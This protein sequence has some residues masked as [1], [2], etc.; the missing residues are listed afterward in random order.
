MPGTMTR[1]NRVRTSAG[2]LRLVSRSGRGSGALRSRHVALIGADASP[3][4]TGFP[5]FTS[6]LH[7][8][9]SDRAGRVSR[10]LLSPMT[11]PPDLVIAAV[12]GP[13]AVAAG[14]EFAGRHDVPLLVVVQG[15]TVPL[16]EDAGTTGARLAARLENRSLGRADRW[17][18][19]GSAARERLLRLGV[20][21]SRI[22]RLPYW[23]EP[24]R[25]GPQVE[26]ERLAVRRRLGRPAGFL[27]VCPVGARTSGAGTVIAAAHRLAERTSDV[28]LLLVGR[29]PRLRSSAAAAATLPNLTVL[30]LPETDYAAALFAADLVVLPEGTDGPDG[31]DAGRFAAAMAAGRPTI[32][33]SAD[34]DHLAAELN[35]AETAALALPPERP[36]QLADAIEVLR[37]TPSALAVMASGARQYTRAA[38]GPETAAA[39]L[40]EIAGRTLSRSSGS[41]W[42]GWTR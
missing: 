18:V 2:S 22:D 39:M 28:Q 24:V 15:E 17:A 3:Y 1:L 10:P 11:E 40:D 26:A 34:S 12:P 14:A 37:S 36:D 5:G 21:D 31:A 4:V 20:D 30:D 41:T 38:M 35:R 8:L 23:A 7:E 27:V 9:L 29:G 25:S 32:T 33:T 16:T 13:G 19:T 6:A 42:W